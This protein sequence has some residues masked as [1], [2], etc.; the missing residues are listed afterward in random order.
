MA[1]GADRTICSESKTFAIG[2][3]TDVTIGCGIEKWEHFEVHRTMQV[4]EGVRIIFVWDGEFQ[5]KKEDK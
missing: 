2:P 1:D 4:K 5:V 3:Y